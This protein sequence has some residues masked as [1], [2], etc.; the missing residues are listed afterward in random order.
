MVCISFFCSS[1]I[2]GIYSVYKKKLY[3][4]F[5]LGY[6]GHLAICPLIA[7]NEQIIVNFAECEMNYINSDGALGH[8]N[9]RKE[10]AEIY[11]VIF[12]YKYMISA[13]LYICKQID[14]LLDNDIFRTLL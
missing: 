8:I 2:W 13:H 4:T 7:I 5:P 10:S 6:V 12:Y 11:Q 14:L 3:V 9:T 1:A